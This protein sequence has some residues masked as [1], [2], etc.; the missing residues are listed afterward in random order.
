[1]ASNVWI[2]Y[3]TLF[4][5]A[6]LLD[7]ISCDD[8]E[9]EEPTIT[10]SIVNSLDVTAEHCDD[11]DWEDRTQ[12]VLRTPFRRVG[13]SLYELHYIPSVWTERFDQV[14]SHDR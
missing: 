13:R 3:Y 7:T 4:F 8:E 14:D 5:L 9:S 2:V 6:L 1:M 12:M 10:I 11:F